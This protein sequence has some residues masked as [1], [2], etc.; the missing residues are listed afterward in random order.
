MEQTLF[1]PDWRDEVIFSAGGPQPQ[2]L[3]EDAKAKV[4]VVG[5]N[6]AAA[7]PPMPAAPAS[8]TSSK[9]RSRWRWA[10]RFSRCRTARPC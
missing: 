2:V 7:S 3:H 6:P 10:M 5:S 8:T 4:V 9:A 1:F